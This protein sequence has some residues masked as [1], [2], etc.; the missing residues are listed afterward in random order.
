MKVIGLTGGIGSGKSTVS[1]F[2]AEMGAIILDADKVGREALK[3]GGEVWHQVVTA[4]GKHVI[5]SDGDIDRALTVRANK[6]SAASK[7]KIEAAGGK[8]EEVAHAAKGE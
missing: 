2:L 1:Q 6:F 4:F 7:V 8:A 5:T 3:P